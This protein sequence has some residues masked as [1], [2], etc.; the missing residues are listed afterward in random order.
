MA[1]LDFEWD[2]RKSEANVRKHGVSFEEAST[3]FSDE[4]A[5]FMAD[6]NHSGEEDRFVLLGLSAA[7]RTLVVCHCLR[8]GQHIIRIIPA[9][10]ATRTERERYNRRWAP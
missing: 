7:L 8:D 1:E 5:L 3:V 9:R 2:P 4:H 10:K 6:P